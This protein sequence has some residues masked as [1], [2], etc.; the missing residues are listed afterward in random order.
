MTDQRPPTEPPRAPYPIRVALAAWVVAEAAAFFGLAYLIGFW[1]T[2]LVF[3]ATTF[4]GLVVLQ[5]AGARSLAAAREYLNSG[6]DPTREPPNGYAVGGA[7][8]LI[9]PGFVTDLLGLLLLFPP[10]RLLFRGLGR[11]LAAR[12]PQVRFGQRGD[13]IDGEVVDERDDEPGG[14][15]G[16][17]KGPRTIE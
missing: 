9:V 15:P 10:T 11:Y 8:A 16:H 1:Y 5:Y 2:A 4:V 17:E 14:G 12:T 6:G 13:V 7:V 3:V